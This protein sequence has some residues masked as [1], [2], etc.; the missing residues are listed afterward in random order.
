MG[1]DP[2]NMG[3]PCFLLENLGHF[4]EILENSGK[5]MEQLWETRKSHGFG[6]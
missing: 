6:K 5:M 4:E 3:N 1:N 2:K